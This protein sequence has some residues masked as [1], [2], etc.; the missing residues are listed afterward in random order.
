MKRFVLEF[1]RPVVELEARLGELRAQPSAERPEIA[2]EIAFLESQLERLRRRLF[3]TLGPW[4]RVQIARHPDRPRTLD[5]IGSICDDFEPLHGDRLYRDDPA[6]VGGMAYLNGRA[7]VIVGHQKG[8]T[9]KEN[10]ARNFGMPHP[11]GF[12]KARRVMRMAAKYKRPLLCFVDTPGAYPGTG[13]EERGQAIAIAVN[14]RDMAQLPVP[15]VVVNIGEGGSGGA[16]GLGV[17]DRVIMLENAYYSVITPEGCA[18]I[19][20]HD[21]KRA[22]EAATALKLTAESLQSLGLVDEV[23]KEPIGGAHRDPKLV[24]EKVKATIIASLGEL[25]EMKPEQL[26]KERYVRLRGIGRFEEVS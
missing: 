3:A 13:A 4:E 2:E 24:S 18:S 1:E 6:V 26:V 14:L 23:V 16:L 19:L 8:R 5:Y 7:V 15:I 25:G 17:G 9:A 22:P 20:W 10:A 12:W 21:E 11:E